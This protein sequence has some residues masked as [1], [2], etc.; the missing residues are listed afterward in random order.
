MTHA[1]PPELL[2]KYTSH[3]RDDFIRMMDFFV[4]TY[5][6]L[7]VKALI[8]GFSIGLAL[9]FNSTEYARRA[10]ELFSG[11]IISTGEELDR[12]KDGLVPHYQALVDSVPLEGVN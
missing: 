8:L 6:D 12:Y 7:D 1:A 4:S 2:D 10:Y 9:A 3:D 11:K 5:P